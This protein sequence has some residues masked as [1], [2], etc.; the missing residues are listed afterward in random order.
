[1]LGTSYSETLAEY[2]RDIEGG[3][4]KATAYNAPQVKKIDG[5]KLKG[6]IDEIPNATFILLPIRDKTLKIG[7]LSSQFEKD[8]N[9]II[10]KNIKFTP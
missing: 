4:I 2:S 3:T 5:I 9:N 6:T 7:T 8:L 1:V 10:L